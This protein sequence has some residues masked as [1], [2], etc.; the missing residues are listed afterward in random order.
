MEAE[1]REL[2][3]PFNLLAKPIRDAL[4][5]RRFLKPTE[6]QVE[7]IPRILR[8]ENILLSA[9]T[10]TGKTEAAVL[11]VLDMLLKLPERRSGIYALYITPLRALNRDL[12]DRIGWWCGKVGVTVAVRHGDTDNRERVLQARNPPEM[13][14]TT[15][16]TLQAIL[17]GRIMRKHLSSVRWVIVDE[18]HEF[19]ED[20]RGSQL[21]LA[22][23]RLTL[24]TSRDFQRIGLSATIGSLEE[25]GRFLVGVGRR[26]SVVKVPVAKHMKLDVLYPQ[27]QPEDYDLADKLYT[28]PEV[29]ARLRLLRKLIE[30][31]ESVLLFTN[32]RSIAEVLASRFRVWDD[33]IPISIHHSS[34]SKPARIMAEVGLKKGDLKGLVCTSSLELGIDIGRVDLT[35]QYMSPRQVTRLVQRVGRS[36]H[37]LGRTSK[38]IIVTMDG[39]DTLEAIVIAR[40][41]LKEELEPAKIP[42]KPYDVLAHQIAGLLMYRRRWRFDE[43]LEAFRRAYP[44]RDLSEEDMVKVLSYM[45]DRYPRLAWVSFEDRIVVKPVRGKA[46]YEY[47]F[48]NLSMIPDEKQYLVY[49][50]VN[51]MP[52]GILDE[53]FVAEYGEPGIKFI[54][55]GRPWMLMS[56]VGDRIYVK[57]VDDPTGA[58]PSWVGEEIPVPFEVASEVGRIRG[59]LEEYFNKG[60]SLESSARRIARLYPADSS[61]ILEALK[62]SWSHLAQ[63]YP[64]PTDRRMVIEGWG[65]YIILHVHGGSLINRS[66]GRI[67]GDIITDRYGVSV[68]VQQDPYR[69]IIHVPG[70]SIAPSEIASIIKSLSSDEVRV[71][72][73]EAARKTGLFKR[74]LVH[75]A[76]R[77]SAISED[78][79]FTDVSLNQIAESLKG[80][81]V[82]EEALK[83]TLEKDMDIDG[84]IK[85]IIEPLHNGSMEIIVVESS[86]LSPLAKMGIERIGRKTDIIPADKMR[87]IILES[88]K[89]RLMN[90]SRTLVCT[91][92]FKYIETVVLKLL[93]DVRCPLCGSNRLVPL[94]MDENDAYKLVFKVKRDDRLYDELIRAGSIVSRYGL[95]AIYALSARGV[96]LDDVEAILEDEPR[97]TDRFFELIMD[98]E[99]KALARRYW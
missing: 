19:A 53:A 94:N 63:G 79:D 64:L 27:P 90:E 37:S 93:S 24:L 31:Y 58:I 66:L 97:L 30:E 2:P 78:V 33:S 68:A 99:R 80:T 15:P 57:P 85:D 51:D 46:L 13:L 6:P 34:L 32:T 43:I 70:G 20:K 29:A 22:L 83:E 39:D 65:D 47:Y 96:N 60:L 77:F 87:R 72:G 59:K 10:G 16:E 18:I 14:I 23:E 62:E 17:T 55:Q 73:L 5:E 11:P 9:P 40:R 52:V 38:G 76:R 42:Y 21:S 8:G 28:R 3:Y 95:P 81:V 54:C 35:V 92:C 36:G 12:L 91:E 74:R 56:I 71:R 45:H 26:V 49:D 25:V 82:Y 4:L 69:I 89:A 88:V 41:A 7:V 98:A 61:T 50:E 48:E 67:L 75:V 1:I 44:Y 84:L 86:E